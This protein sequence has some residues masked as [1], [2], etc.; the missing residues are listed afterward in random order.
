MR[1]MTRRT[2]HLLACTAALGLAGSWAYA[3]EPE[4]EPPLDLPAPSDATA[5]L[6][7]H[8]GHSREG[9]D[10]IEHL[11]A[12]ELPFR[13]IVNPS[14]FVPGSLSL[15]TTSDG[16]LLS[17]ARLPTE[18]PAHFILPEHRSRVS[19]YGSEELV[20]LLLDA[21]ERSNT[22]DPQIRLGIGNLSLQDGGDSPW[23]RSHNNGR[24][25]DVAFQFVDSEGNPVEPST[26][27]YVDRRGRAR[28]DSGWTFDVA[29][30]WI[31]VE[32]LLRSEE[33]Q[34]Q[35]LFVYDPLREMML[36]HAASIGVD[37]EL[38]AR[39]ERVLKQPSDSARHD[40]HLHVRVYCSLEDRLEGCVN[41]GPEWPHIDTYEREV[42]V[43]VRELLRGLMTAEDAI[44]SAC[45]EFLARLLPRGQATLIA[46]ALPYQSPGV[47][48]ATLSLLE[49]LDQHGVF[50]AIVPLAESSPDDEVRERAF[51]VL[52]RLGDPGAARWLAEVAIRDRRPLAD[53]RSARE[54]ALHALR[55][56][57]S[58]E[59]VPTA[60][61]LVA[62]ERAAVREAAEVVLRRSTLVVPDESLD[63]AIEHANF[64][65][66]W[67]AERAGDGRDGWIA[68]R[69]RREGL[70]LG[71]FR[72][73]P[74]WDTLIDAL[75]KR[76]EHLRFVADRLL[77]E[78]SG[79]G[80]PSKAGANPSGSATGATKSPDPGPVYSRPLM[81]FTC[82]I[83]FSYSML[84]AEEP[85]SRFFN[86]ERTSTSSS[87]ERS[88]ACFFMTAAITTR[89]CRSSAKTSATLF[90]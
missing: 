90:D 48:I 10:D 58:A 56:T 38:L 5:A 19:H 70:N 82:A 30:N 28:D 75:D 69:F 83:A 12:T 73:T 74:P 84:N 37:E 60:I 40:D 21:A 45:V 14:R 57:P 11:A 43:R 63:T 59:L 44:A 87:S 36:A 29:R 18:S 20:A 42:E 77:V 66:Q 27:V 25:A 61:A 81:R 67:Y 86:F 89:I 34:I 65:K 2:R 9:F 1:R 52:G 23:S 41:W 49:D 22:I 71:D 15:G 50:G 39:A 47:Q 85:S 54:L 3:Q 55:N 17:S 46:A 88:R 72:A 8:G 6:S 26:L 78:L 53:G 24:D 7:R 13:E 33:A 32:S 80:R 51:E 68:S 35:W 64:W 16:T 76:D 79:V 62:D 4:P 31:V